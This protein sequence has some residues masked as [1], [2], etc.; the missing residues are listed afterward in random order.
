ML[1]KYI[2]LGLGLGT[3]WGLLDQSPAFLRSDDII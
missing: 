1:S 3:K 2:G